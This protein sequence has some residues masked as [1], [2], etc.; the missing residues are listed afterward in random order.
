M[1]IVDTIDLALLH[2]PPQRQLRLAEEASLVALPP[3]LRPLLRLGA[4]YLV[5]LRLLALRPHLLEEGC[6]A[7]PPLLLLL[8]LRPA[9]AD[10]S[11]R[12]LLLRHRR[13]DA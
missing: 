5:Q 3:Q 6:L 7:P 11:E 13:A 4:D 1:I 9:E 2:L 8:R 12:Q 10:Y